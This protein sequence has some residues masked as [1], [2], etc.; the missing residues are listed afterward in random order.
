MELI[1]TAW[2]KNEAP[3]LPE[4]LEFHILQGFTKFLIYDN[5]ST[6]ETAL[7]LE[8]YIKQGLVEH[9]FYPPE[10][11]QRNNFWVM[12]STLAE[13]SNQ[14]CWLF[15]HSVDERMFSPVG[16]NLKEVLKDYTQFGGLSVAWEEF[17]SSDKLIK[18]SGLLTDRFTITCKDSSNHI[19]TIVQPKYAT[20]HCGNPHNFIFKPGYFSVDE[21]KKVVNGPFNNQNPYTYALIKNH[22]YRT[23]SLEE[24]NNKQL[25]G[26]LDH[27]GQENRPRIDSDAQWNW[28]HHKAK[29]GT[30]IEL[31]KYSQDVKEA[32][33][34]RYA[35]Y[36][37]L[38]TILDGWYALSKIQ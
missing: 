8:P 3:Y 17:N 1:A 19:K 20:A 10:I 26:L 29:L 18:E 2:V 22:H 15:H 7:I 25:K 12:N 13:F 32:I 4:W 36:P 21:N 33:T 14:D 37:E 9:R 24:F 34:N 27:P 38:F 30:N 16:T 31:L 6:D 5:K 28:C 11:T 35:F 23:M